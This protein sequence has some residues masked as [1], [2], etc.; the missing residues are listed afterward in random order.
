MRAGK[1]M[2]RAAGSLRLVGLWVAVGAVA[3]IPTT[4][5]AQSATA[6]DTL[7]PMVKDEN[8]WHPTW[9]PDGREIAYSA[10]DE[11]GD[12][13]IF[14]ITL[15]TG[16]I[17]KLTD[18]A[19]RDWRPKWS[20]D[21]RLIAFSSD[22][23]GNGELYTVDPRTGHVTRLTRTA[24]DEDRIG[25]S[26][27][28]RGL[29]HDV[30]SGDEWDLWTLDLV[31]GGTRQLTIDPGFEGYP[32]WSPD[33]TAIVFN[34]NL[35]D[36]AGG[37]AAR[38][39]YLLDLASGARSRL[40]ENEANDQSP[41][42]S[43]DGR[44]IAYFSNRD[45]NAEIYVMAADGARH[46]RLTDDPEWDFMPRW[47][48]DGS[49]IAFDSRRD[50]RRG[51]YLMDS[52]GSQVRKI[53]NLAMSPFVEQA[54]AHG[55]ERAVAAFN[56]AVSS[57]RDPDTL[58]LEPEVLALARAVSDSAPLTAVRLL[59]INLVAHPRSLL[60]WTTLGDQLSQLRLARAARNAY[61][62]ALAIDPTHAPALAGLQESRAR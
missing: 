25:W 31:S 1:L 54:R 27:D 18:N 30:G 11:E 10:W 36:P 4:G 50:G 3:A 62:Q 44:H 7:A 20:P 57:G 15:A 16:A 19:H 52:D 22:R 47:S 23:N 59:E 60:G 39:I 35:H 12:Y 61:F 5:A 13:E 32:D 2:T 34:S 29:V 40:T 56:H 9:S 53:T 24:H 41:A 37:G 14:V 55:A 28:S 33:G 17:R 49:R 43:P 26:P 58:F 6:P 8:H 48:P 42:W 45:G 38:E 21:G 51:V 46:T